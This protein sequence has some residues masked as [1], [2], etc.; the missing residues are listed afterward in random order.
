M[1]G[2]WA[3]SGPGKEAI[4]NGCNI[5]LEGQKELDSLAVAAGSFEDIEVEASIAADHP[6]HLVRRSTGTVL[7]ASHYMSSESFDVV[8][9]ESTALDQLALADCIALEG[10]QPP[11]GYC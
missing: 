11:S 3:L 9:T 4:G 1:L 6:I 7:A 2:S 5:G 10:K 8:G